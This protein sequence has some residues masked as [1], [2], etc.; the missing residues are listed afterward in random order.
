[1]SKNEEKAFAISEIAP[2][3]LNALVKNLMRGMNI[4]DPAEAVRRINSREWLVYEPS[5]FRRK[6][7]LI[8]FSVTSDGTTP[9]GWKNR[10]LNK[11][12]NL[13]GVN[14]DHLIPT[15]GV[16]TDIIIYESEVDIKKQINLVSNHLSIEV[17]CLV[18]DKFT[19]KD[20]RD[21]GLYKIILITGFKTA[22]FFNVFSIHNRG[23]GNWLSTDCFEIE[24]A[25]VG[26]G[27]AGVVSEKN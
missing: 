2:G 23:I 18:R 22:Q 16:T 11:G 12:F 15:V 3:K 4:N 5:N 8:H 27:L 17:A 10:L 26:L 14:I 21:M 7:G 13:L 6:N 20:L 24:D 1:M 19:D 25:G 9:E